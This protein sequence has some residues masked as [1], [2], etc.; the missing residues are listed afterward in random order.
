MNVNH[1]NKVRHMAVASPDKE[2]PGGG[3]DAAVESTEG[4][5]GNEERHRPGEPAQSSVPKGHCNSGGV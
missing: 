4:R 5:Q 2:K 3:E 1:G